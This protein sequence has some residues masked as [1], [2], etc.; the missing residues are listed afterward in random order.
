MAYRNN[1]SESTAE[2]P[3]LLLSVWREERAYRVGKALCYA[4]LF[5]SI[6]ATIADG[7]W[8]APSV[9]A[10]DTVLVFGCMLSIFWLRH[11]SRPTYYWWPLYWA[12][13][14]SIFPSIWTTGGINGPFLGIDLAALYVLAAVMEAKNRSIGYFIFLLCHIPFFYAVEIFYPHSTGTYPPPILTF[15]IVGVTFTGIF[16][17]VDGMLRTE[18]E[19]S[20]EFSEHYRRLSAT[21]KQLR[22]AQAITR[23][24]SWEWDLQ[25]D[26][27]SWSDELFEIY[28]VKRENF[29]PSFQ[30]YLNRLSTEMREKVLQTIETSIATG[31]DFSFEN[32]CITSEGERYILSRGR[33]VKDANGKVIKM[34]GT[35]QDITDRK[36]IESQLVEARNELE[37]RV[38]ERTLQLAQSLEREK[39]AKE[40]AENANQAKMQFLANMSH[41]IRTP[42]NSILGFSELL[43][44]K[45]HSPESQDYVARIRGNGAH[46]LHLI[47]DILDLSK[48]EAGRIPI[49]KSSFSLKSLIENVISSFQPALK[50][51]DLELKFIYQAEDSLRISTDNHRVSQILTNLLSNSIK[52]SEA[53]TLR[54]KVTCAPINDTTQLR[55]CVDLEDAGIGISKE[56]QKTLFQPFSQGDSSIARK[57]GGS[58]LGLVLSKR[59]SEALGGKLELKSSVPG[60]GSHFYFEI[61]VERVTDDEIKTAV[62]EQNLVPSAKPLLEKKI[63]LAED[64]PDNAFLI[65]HYIKSM[66]A[67]IDIAI[68]GLQAVKMAELAEYD[69]ILMDIQ[70]PGMDGLEATRRIR[71]QGFKKPI[72]ALTAH[73]LPAEAER[74]IQ[75]GCDLHLT[76]PINR[77]EL[78]GALSERLEV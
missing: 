66:G 75:A 78:I 52:F 34:L 4:G 36:S 31:K 30:G 38:E 74:S 57:F 55:L 63:L 9:F 56:N 47:D 50:A 10:T 39:V 19:L 45:E 71:Q 3:D 69:C 29:D 22:E 11:P 40:L 46:L 27:V 68:D 67:G 25:A 41:E 44:A 33:V 21:K 61:P 18:R 16:V 15:V 60:V 12:L 5:L 77:T 51:K 58:G 62:K 17:C 37:H 32:K 73:A 70:M 28:E 59:I 8:S 43:A 48:F 65:S 7:I 53:G 26:R 14:I 13:W 54:L 35:S 76:K 23:M 72:I 64:S 6:I 42:M 2:N 49:H 1:L 24:G 20:L